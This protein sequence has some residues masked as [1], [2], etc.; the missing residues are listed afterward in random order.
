MRVR[1][2]RSRWN[3]DL[4]PNASRESV[5]NVDELAIYE[6]PAICG[7]PTFFKPLPYSISY[8]NTHDLNV[9]RSDPI[10]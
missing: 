8:D 3:D 1:I 7:R 6:Y 5:V 2:E 10:E 9:L 4:V